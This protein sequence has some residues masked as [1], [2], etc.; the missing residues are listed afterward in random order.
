MG[1]LIHGVYRVIESLGHRV[2][3]VGGVVGWERKGELKK[4]F[5]PLRR[6]SHAPFRICFISS[7]VRGLCRVGHRQGQEAQEATEVQEV[8]KLPDA[9]EGR[10]DREAAVAVGEGH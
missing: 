3:R 5:S 1:R 9:G 7:R 4:Y 6:F 2:Y 8:L 10:E